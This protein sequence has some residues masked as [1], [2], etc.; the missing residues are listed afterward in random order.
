MIGKNYKQ[1]KKKQKIDLKVQN[2]GGGTIITNEIMID[3][4]SHF[5]SS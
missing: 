2:F 4:Q 5:E 1:I 3:G